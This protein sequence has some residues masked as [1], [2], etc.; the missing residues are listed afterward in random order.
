MKWRFAAIFLTVFG[1]C[2][3]L[4]W[5]TDF[6]AHYQAVGIRAAALVSPLVNGWFLEATPLGPAAGVF[7][8][9]TLEMDLH[10]QLAALSMGLMPLL[11]LIAATP[12]QSW[13]EMLRAVAIGVPLYFVVDV[14]IVLVYPFV[15]DNPNTFKDTI[16]VFSGLVG[17][18]V[19]PLGIWFAVTYRALGS[20]W[21]IANETLAADANRL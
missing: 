21:Q 4:W 19:A 8:R 5:L 11:S 17:F 9:G 12:N 1:A 13:R 20:L 15:L 6:G 7:R 16:G 10:I 18:V 2:L 3:P 14:L